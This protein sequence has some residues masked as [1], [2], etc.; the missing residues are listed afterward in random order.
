M[1]PQTTVQSRLTSIRRVLERLESELRRAEIVIAS[2]PATQE[3]R[4]KERLQGHKDAHRALMEQLR[5]LKPFLRRNQEAQVRDGWIGG[6][7]ALNS[8]LFGYPPQASLERD[9]LLRSMGSSQN[10]GEKRTLLREAERGTH[11]LH[12]ASQMMRQ[13]RE[14]MQAALEVTQEVSHL[15]KDAINQHG[16]LDSVIGAGRSLITRLERR[17]T[18]DRILIGFATAVFFLIVAYIWKSRMWG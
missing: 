18:T 15:A 7:G 10:T 5:A 6:D 3:A 16:E 4:A 11:A 1:A 13:E 17:D 14:R 9:E 12:E 8:F 2:K